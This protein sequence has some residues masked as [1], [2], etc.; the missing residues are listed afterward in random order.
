MV[1]PPKIIRHRPQTTQKPR[2]VKKQTEILG[3]LGILAI[4]K[5]KKSS[6]ISVS[7]VVQKIK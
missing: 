3:D 5:V 7:S 6:V 2:S 4:K 1:K